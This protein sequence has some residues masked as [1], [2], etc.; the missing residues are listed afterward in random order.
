MFGWGINLSRFNQ[1]NLTV[2][3]LQVSVDFTGPFVSLLCLMPDD[4][5]SSREPLGR[6]G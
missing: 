3:N 1:S 4:F 6:K 5:Y 2:L